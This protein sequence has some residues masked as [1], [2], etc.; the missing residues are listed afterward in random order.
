MKFRSPNPQFEQKKI[1]TKVPLML[2]VN[3]FFLFWVSWCAIDANHICKTYQDLRWNILFCLI[4]YWIFNWIMSYNSTETS[5]AWS[6][7]EEELITYYTGPSKQYCAFAYSLSYNPMPNFSRVLI[8]LL[9][10]FCRPTWL[11][12]SGLLHKYKPVKYKARQKVGSQLS[13]R[14]TSLTGWKYNFSFIHACTLR[15]PIATCISIPSLQT[16]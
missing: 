1:L 14:P 4:Y 3:F 13:Y 10:I 12:Y 6:D 9:L 8:G 15:L 16:I 2:Q 5:K 7:P 11:V